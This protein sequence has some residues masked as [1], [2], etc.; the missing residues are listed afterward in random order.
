MHLHNQV[1][2]TREQF[3]Q[4]LQEY[5]ADKPVCMLNIIKFKGAVESDQPTGEELYKRYMQ[6]FTPFMKSSRARLL[7]KGKVRN[8]LIGDSTD[9][10]DIAFIVRYPTIADFE[11]MIKDPEYQKITSDRTL[12]LEYGGLIAMEEEYWDGN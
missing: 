8:T 4:L 5:P 3:K 1:N 6:N 12:A 7:W 9:Q 11:N 10:P 2:P